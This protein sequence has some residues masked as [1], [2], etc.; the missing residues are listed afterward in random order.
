M[1]F[2]CERTM[3]AVVMV[4][5]LT[6]CTRGTFSC[7]DNDLG[8]RDDLLDGGRTLPSSALLYGDGPRGTVPPLDAWG[9]GSGEANPGWRG[10]HTAVHRTCQK[11]H[12]RVCQRICSGD[13]AVGR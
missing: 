13:A 8:R 5:T 1:D 2:P 4:C 12:K 3:T 7:V 6:Q 10:T 11:E 9:G